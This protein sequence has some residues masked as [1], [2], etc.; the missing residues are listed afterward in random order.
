MTLTHRSRLLLLAAGIGFLPGPAAAQDPPPPLRGVVVD[1]TG[2]PVPQ[3]DIIAIGNSRRIEGP[4]YA[5]TDAAGR[6]VFPRLE[7]GNYT[8]T[9]RRIGFVPIQVTVGLVA[10]TPR[11]LRFEMQRMPQVLADLV[12]DERGGPD[13][14][15]RNRPLFQGVVV[16]AAGRPVPDADV[17]AGGSTL[18]RRGPFTR[19][20]AANG[21]FTFNDLQAGRYF[22]TVRRIGFVP[23]RVALTFES[24]APRTIRFELQAMPQ[25]LADVEV[26]EDGFDIDR[27]SRRVSAGAYRGTL[28]TRDDLEAMA[29]RVLGDA[30]GKTLTNV[31][32]E[33]F[34]EPNLGYS[35]LWN[36]PGQRLSEALRRGRDCPPAVSVNG[37]PTRAGWAVND[38]QPEHV[39]AVEIYKGPQYPFPFDDDALLTGRALIGSPMAGTCGQL[40]IIWLRPGLII[41]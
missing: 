37:R 27:I 2:V 31:S 29:P 15:T 12:V 7:P 23:L 38:I 19:R 28:L 6:F 25:Q 3:A 11:N 26:K 8:L 35:H 16:D 21:R 22:V 14:V 4:H 39:E 32:A 10:G 40:V 41:E 9:V 1:T 24:Q 30:I 36:R 13:S 33:N 18:R 5:R 34:D 17:V 20:T